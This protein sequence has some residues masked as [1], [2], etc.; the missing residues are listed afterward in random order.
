MILFLGK[1]EFLYRIF[2]ICLVKKRCG[3][4]ILTPFC[5]KPVFLDDDFLICN[6]G[7]KTTFFSIFKFSVL[8]ICS[9]NT[10]A[11][12]LPISKGDCS[13]DEMES[14]INFVKGSLPKP[15]KQNSSGSL[16]PFSF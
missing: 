12:I 7:F 6:S 11:A 4:L 16:I 15:K 10:L 3:N 8:L 13:T 5:Y 1:E 14:S 2:L 9:K